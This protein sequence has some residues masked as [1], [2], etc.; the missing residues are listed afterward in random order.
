M[1]IEPTRLDNVLDLFLTSNHTLVQKVEIYPGIADHDVMVADVIKPTLGC[2]EPRSVPL[3]IQG[4][5]TFL[6]IKFPDFSLI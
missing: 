2:Q 3:Y 6:A 1:V 5:H 4:G